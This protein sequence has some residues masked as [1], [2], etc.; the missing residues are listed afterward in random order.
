MRLICIPTGCQVNFVKRIKNYNFFHK[1]KKAKNIEKKFF[2]GKK[3]LDVKPH[4]RKIP[5]IGKEKPYRD[6]D[7]I[8]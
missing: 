7:L 5:L 3:D 8:K 1:K 4:Y 6:I 2:S